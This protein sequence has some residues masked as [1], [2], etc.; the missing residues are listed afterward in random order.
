[1]PERNYF[2]ADW[3]SAKFKHSRNFFC[4]ES[5]SDDSRCL[6]R[7]FFYKITPLDFVEFIKFRIGD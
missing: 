3:S 4:G 6:R 1:M 2:R 5:D 7:E